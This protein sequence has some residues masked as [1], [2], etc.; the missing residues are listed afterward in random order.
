MW[1]ELGAAYNFRRGQSLWIR[2]QITKVLAQ[3]P[4]SYEI[5]RFAGLLKDNDAQIP[6][7]AVIALEKATNRVLGDGKL[8]LNDKKRLWIQHFAKAENSKTN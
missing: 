2:S 5:P 6:Q 7:Y 1:K 8:S 4:R 3:D